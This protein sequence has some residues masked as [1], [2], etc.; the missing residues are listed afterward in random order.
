MA[1]QIL[2]FLCTCTH[3]M[4][5]LQ[6]TIYCIR[7]TFACMNL[8]SVLY[9]IASEDYVHQFLPVA[10]QPS[11]LNVRVTLSTL[12]D[13]RIEGEENFYL[14]AFSNSTQTRATSNATIVI[15]DSKGIPSLVVLERR[16]MY[17]ES[18]LQCCHFLSWVSHPGWSRSFYTRRMIMCLRLSYLMEAFL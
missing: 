18:F 10:F 8:W 9:C 17:N 11:A 13:L 16:Y 4:A 14:I 6:V 15:A 5:L 1:L 2:Y 12:R 3:W 7:C